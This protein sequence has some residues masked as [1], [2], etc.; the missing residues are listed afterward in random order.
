MCLIDVHIPWVCGWALCPQGIVRSLRHGCPNNNDWLRVRTPS[1]L[2]YVTS[3]ALPWV[4]SWACLYFLSDCSMHRIYPLLCSS[5]VIHDHLPGVLASK[6]RNWFFLRWSRLSASFGI[7]PAGT[8]VSNAFP[9]SMS[10]L[11]L[12]LRWTSSCSTAYK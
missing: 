8:A 6:P 4:T 11:H 3:F 12:S 7:L 2:L 1:Y 9:I 10:R 5:S